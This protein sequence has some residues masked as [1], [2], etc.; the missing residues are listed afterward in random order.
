MS[1]R[2]VRSYRRRDA[3]RYRDLPERPRTRRKPMTGLLIVALVAGIASFSA[4]HIQAM[5][6]ASSTADSPGGACAA[7]AAAGSP[8]PAM[9]DVAAVAP[10]TGAGTASPPAAAASVPTS[11]A[12]S[13]PATPAT[14]GPAAPA[15]TAPGGPASAA[16]ASTPPGA[17]ATAAPSP[18]AVPTPAAS[19][20]S[21]RAAPAPPAPAT[22]TPCRPATPA[23]P[24][25]PANSSCDIIVPAHPLTAAG[26]ATPYRLTGPDGAP[27]KASGCT[28]ANGAN[29]GAFV[30]ATILDQATG[31]LWV[32]EPL[33]ITK[34]TRP[35]VTPVVPMLPAR[36]VVTID[37]G[38][39]GGNLRL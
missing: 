1:Y 34:G 36:A 30:Q 17:T 15:S 21:T 10:I 22:A 27:P 19:A 23:A 24:P 25:P 11:A 12:T 3:R 29:I 13:S 7:P 26:L 35:A 14:T 16:P 33:V 37:V 4:P 18:T 9:S 38:F 5:L 39:N 20:T 2:R 31:K 32:Y 6:S 28:M 8:R